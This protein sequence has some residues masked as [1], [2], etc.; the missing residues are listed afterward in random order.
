MGWSGGAGGTGWWPSAVTADDD[1]DSANAMSPLALTAG[2]TV[3]ESCGVSVAAGLES[4][5]GFL[6]NCAMLVHSIFRAVAPHPHRKLHSAACGSTRV[7]CEITKAKTFWLEVNP[8]CLRMLPKL[9]DVEY[10]ELRRFTNVADPSKMH[11]WCISLQ[12]A[13]TCDCAE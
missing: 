4:E 6:R 1:D 11:T 9:K 3:C 7:T 2:V 10:F 5:R 13:T 8:H 12:D